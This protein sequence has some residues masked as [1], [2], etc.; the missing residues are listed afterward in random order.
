MSVKII[1]N[2]D[3]IKDNDAPLG[4][5]SDPERATNETKQ[6]TGTAFL[7]AK[8][9]AA[10]GDKTISERAD[11]I[12]AWLAERLADLVHDT[13]VNVQPSQ[14]LV[15]AAAHLVPR[16]RL[17]LYRTAIRAARSERPELHFLTS[18]A[19]PPYSF[20]IINS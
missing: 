15:L 18:G 17:E 11:E 14:A 10:Q 3:A 16:E 1:W 20:T 2:P 12:A 9:R 8:Q 5:R 19:W 6:G 4:A 7:I 13:V